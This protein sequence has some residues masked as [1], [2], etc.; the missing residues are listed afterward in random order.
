MPEVHP[1]YPLDPHFAGQSG[2]KLTLEPLRQDGPLALSVH[3]LQGISKITLRTLEILWG[4]ALHNVTIWKSD[5]LFESAGAILPIPRTGTLVAASFDV[6]F[7]NMDRPTMVH[8]RPPFTLQIEPHCDTRL[9]FPWID[10]RG[11][12]ATLAKVLALAALVLTTAL[13]PVL[14]PDPDGDD[15]EHP[16]HH[17]SHSVASVR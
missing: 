7:H 6:Q 11:F 8:I 15:D 12:R 17:W 16:H 5:D 3:D 10:K 9:V 4:N 1:H 13:A 14:D 2:P